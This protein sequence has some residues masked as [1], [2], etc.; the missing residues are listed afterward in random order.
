LAETYFALSAV[1]VGE[2]RR[3]NEK[4]PELSRTLRVFAVIKARGDTAPH[5]INIT[6]FGAFRSLGPPGPPEPLPSSPSR[7]YPEGPQ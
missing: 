2:Q 6:P 5:W 3:R 4:S 7:S 1:R